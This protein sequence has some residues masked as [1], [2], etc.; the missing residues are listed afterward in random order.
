L[1]VAALASVGA[2]LR[3]AG[4]GAGQTGLF[5]GIAAY[6]L[7]GFLPLVFKW[8]DHVPSPTVVADRTLWSLVLVGLMLTAAGR[9]AEV[10]KALA[11]PETLRSM[12]ISSVILGGN[13]L[14]YV[15][16]VETGQVLETSFGYFINPLMNVLLGV[17]LLGERLNRLQVAAMAIAAIAIAIQAVS[18]GGVPY[19]ALGLALTFAAYGYFRKTARVSSTPGLFV[20]TLLLAPV[21]LGYLV[22]TF[23]QDG[24]PG[25]H[26]D[27]G[28]LLLLMATGP[29]TAVPLLLFAFAI[30][31]LTLTT[32]GMLQYIAPS[33]AFLL[34][35]LVFGE[36]LDPLRLLSFA[37][38]WVSVAVYT[39]DS[40][41]RR[42][43][44]S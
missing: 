20:E 44:A 12:A 42:R 1:E 34:A 3:D 8:V 38:I 29:A 31:R 26:A 11:D 22:F 4:S 35:I 5:A 15:Y 28:T 30:Q 7:W 32:I 19:I 37:L 27:P 39:A 21:A 23:I 43:R 9:L 33:I 41:A 18:L 16:A 36:D 40:V 13:W 25:P 6:S 24:G 17:V 14:I 2:T 10:K